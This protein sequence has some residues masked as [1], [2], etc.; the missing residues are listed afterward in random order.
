MIKL[1][2]YKGCTIEIQ[3]VN[4]FPKSHNNI[5]KISTN[6]FVPILDTLLKLSLY[7]RDTYEPRDLI[8]FCHDSKVDVMTLV[9]SH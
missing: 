5:S 8:P 7:T 2:T 3:K 4:I 1:K 6:V 9:L